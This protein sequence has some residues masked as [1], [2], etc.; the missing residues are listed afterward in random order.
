MA[1]IFINHLLVEGPSDDINE[2]IA[3]CHLNTDR[4]GS[5]DGIDFDPKSDYQNHKD[6]IEFIGRECDT[7]IDRI[8]LNKAKNGIIVC[9][10]SWNCL[11][12]SHTQWM[13]RNFPSL[14]F[15]LEYMQHSHS[16]EELIFSEGKWCLIQYETPDP[17]DTESW[18]S[19]IATAGL[20]DD[21]S[22]ARLNESHG[23]EGLCSE[24]RA[25]AEVQLHYKP[26]LNSADND[27]GVK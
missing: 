27:D 6:F 18:Q 11:F 2:F 17:C 12:G 16:H 22:D 5:D 20:Y 3:W 1:T 8:R 9:L 13:A 24:L 19:S 15:R 4:F 14:T 21:Y 7:K 10:D 25:F 23:I 26:D